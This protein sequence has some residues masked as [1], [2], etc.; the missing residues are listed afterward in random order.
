[1]LVDEDQVLLAL[2]KPGVPIADVLGSERMNGLVA[3]LEAIV[4]P[5]VAAARPLTADA[6][7]SRPSW[8]AA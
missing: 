4:R 3:A 8:R 6:P 2:A 1:M 5:L 7:A